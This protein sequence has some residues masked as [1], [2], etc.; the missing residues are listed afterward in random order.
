MPTALHE[1]EA[2]FT[3]AVL[4]LAKLRGWRSAH[5]RPG[6]VMRGGRWTYETPIDGDAKGFPDLVLIRGRRLL[7][8]E[9]K[10]GR[11]RTTPEQEQWLAAFRLAGVEAFVW[12]PGDWPAVEAT[13]A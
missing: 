9:L 5:F 2:T 6:R 7:V 11:G 8:A 10:S 3:R 13:L 12:K 1:T 4:Q